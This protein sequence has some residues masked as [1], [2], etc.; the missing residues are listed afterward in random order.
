MSRKL[1][2]N[3]IMELLNSN[4]AV[5]VTI[6]FNDGTSYKETKTTL[7]WTEKDGRT[8]F[9]NLNKYAQME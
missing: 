2:N 9:D 3:R 8:A 6:E 1:M 4:E 7:E 5:S